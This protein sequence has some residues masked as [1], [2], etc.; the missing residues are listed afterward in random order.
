MPVPKYLIL[1]IKQPS[2]IIP[3][4]ISSEIQNPDLY[5]TKFQFYYN[6]KPHIYQSLLFKHLSLGILS[7]QT[8]FIDTPK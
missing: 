2:F 8:F 7:W 1:F 5:Y 4:S 3:V 6:S